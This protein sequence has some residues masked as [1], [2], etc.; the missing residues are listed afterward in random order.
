MI[1]E[2]AGGEISSDIIDLYPK[3]KAAVEV[4]L[5]FEKINKLIGQ[6]IPKDT[7]KSILTSLDIKVKNVTEAGLGL[8]IPPY[9]VDVTRP[10]DVI[11]EL[12]RVYGYNNVSF[13]GKF[14]ASVAA[15]DQHEDYRVQE[16]VSNLLIGNG[17]NEILTNSLSAASYSE[18]EIREQEQAPITILNPLSGDLSILRTT[19]L[20][21]ALEVA[22][23]NSNRKQTDLK[24]FEF[25]KTYHR[26]PEERLELPYLSLLF[27]GKVHGASWQ[28]K[29]G[30]LG[31]FEAK[32]VINLI[33]ERLGITGSTEGPLDD[34]AYTEGLVWAVGKKQLAK[35]GVVS[36]KITAHFGLEQ[37][38]IFGHVNWSQIQKLLPKR[39]IAF[40][41]IPK[42]P[43]VRRDLALLLHKDISFKALY[44]LA[45]RTERKL[46]KEVTLFDVYL[47]DACPKG[48]NPMP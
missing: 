23:Y 38:I 3:K 20:F 44:D 1:K 45:Y 30:A 42:Y 25:G 9:R 37:E 32:S 39:S 48:K 13:G 16:V 10:V 24:F 6:E 33:L 34:V 17:F 21:S 11:E 27:S 15:V 5:A 29:A 8:V 2:I 4:F 31:F 35:L 40:K 18:L 36:K 41:P 26:S 28:G 22:A 7:I 46:L 14:N 43:S 12:L 47:G 19:P